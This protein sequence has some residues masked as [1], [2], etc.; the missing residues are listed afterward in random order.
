MRQFV[1]AAGLAGV[2]AIAVTLFAGCASPTPEPTPVPVGPP[3]APPVSPAPPEPAP[4]PGP[5]ADPAIG[6]PVIETPAPGEPAAVANYNAFIFGGPGVDY[7]VYGAFLGAQQA[8]VVGI[9]ESGTWWAVSVPP[10]PGGI[11]WVDGEWVTVTGA[12]SVPTLTTPPVPATTDLVPPAAEDPQATVLVNTYV[13]T[14]PGEVF[15]AYG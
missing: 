4:A 9:S 5:T 10:A 6:I 2:L 7:V 12:E 13:R 1:R 8:K 11:G 15:P 3:E 14:G